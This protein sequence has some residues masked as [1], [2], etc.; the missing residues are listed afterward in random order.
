[1]PYARKAVTPAVATNGTNEVRLAAEITA[2]DMGRAA[3]MAAGRAARA[4]ARVAVRRA[5]IVKGR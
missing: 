1:M 3:T 4:T 2:V 5:N